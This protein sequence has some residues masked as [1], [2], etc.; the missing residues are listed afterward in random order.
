MWQRTASNR[1]QDGTFR[2]PKLAHC[3]SLPKPQPEISHYEVILGFDQTPSYYWSNT[4]SS[5]DTKTPWQMSS[6]ALCD[7]RP[8]NLAVDE[9]LG[10][11]CSLKPPGLRALAAER[12]FNVNSG[13][14]GITSEYATGAELELEWQLIAGSVPK[15]GLS[16]SFRAAETKNEFLRK[17]A[18]VEEK[19]V[20]GGAATRK[21]KSLKESQMMKVFRE[22]VEICRSPTT[23]DLEG[24]T[25][26]HYIEDS[27]EKLQQTMDKCS[28]GSNS[29][30]FTGDASPS[31]ITSTMSWRTA[32]KEALAALV[33]QK[34][35]E[36]LENCDLPTPLSRSILKRPLESFD[37][38]VMGAKSESTETSDRNVV[39]SV[40]HVR[41]PTPL[42]NLGPA[43]SSDVVEKTESS[44]SAVQ[45]ARM[46]LPL[47]IPTRG[48]ASAFHSGYQSSSFAENKH[49]C[50]MGGDKVMSTSSLGRSS[51]PLGEALC[52]S[53]SRAREAEKRAEE[54]FQEYQ[55]VA[56]L[57]FR[58][59]SLSLTYRQLVSSLQ[60]ENACL[61]VYLHRHQQATVLLHQSDFS[62]FSV[63][64]RFAYYRWNLYG[65]DD[66]RRQMSDPFP[67]LWPAEKDK[68]GSFV[69]TREGGTEMIM[70][71]TLSFAFA[72]GLSLAGAGLML[73]WSMGWI[74][75][76]F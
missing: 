64:D 33:A 18:R 74:L 29:L 41:E 7:Q 31:T 24:L 76:A 15:S 17:N 2:A 43:A 42:A 22:S 49:A 50:W 34:T 9:L 61:R 10:S 69:M 32:N 19:D 21:S 44:S 75:L 38:R 73:G 58:E 71:C 51:G 28:Y 6:N 60:A 25:S 1:V 4:W 70:S 52:H 16:A 3:P 37:L 57:L 54:N 20:P 40:L 13:V 14:I 62:P 35:K 56:H 8:E 53:Q 68:A 5:M 47:T 45:S 30:C 48:Q 12:T 65:R 39:D 67:L 63:L 55:K 27:M 46:T 23:E 26:K 59:A 36:T 11:R 66:G 72:L